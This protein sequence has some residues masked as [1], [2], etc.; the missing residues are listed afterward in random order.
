MRKRRQIIG[1]ILLGIGIA[2][3]YVLVCPEAC[4]GAWDALDAAGQ[5]RFAATFQAGWLL[6]SMVTQVLAVHLLRTERV[7]FVES[8]ASWQIVALGLA[9]IVVAALMCMTPLGYV[10]DLAV[11][12]VAAVGALALVAVAYVACVLL[13]RRVYVARHG[14]LL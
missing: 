10:I 7:P 3:L 9:G 11:L 4:G 13:V 12:P 8:R 6:E 2:L 5:L 1:W 14:S